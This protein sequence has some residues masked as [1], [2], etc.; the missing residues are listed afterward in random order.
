MSHMSALDI[1]RHNAD[2]PGMGT[3]DGK[4]ARMSITQLQTVRYEAP[5]WLLELVGDPITDPDEIAACTA[6]G[7]EI[8]ADDVMGW[9]PYNRIICTEGYRL[10]AVVTEEGGIA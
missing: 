10:L 7:Y 9:T 4:D 3:Q 2:E 6:D 1:S 8:L 5:E